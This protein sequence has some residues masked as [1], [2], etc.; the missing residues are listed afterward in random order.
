L[1]DG[2]VDGGGR[3][4]RGRSRWLAAWGR[5]RCGLRRLWGRGGRRHTMNRH[6]SFGD[7]GLGALLGAYEDEVL[8]EI[9]DSHGGGFGVVC[10]GAV[11]DVGD[12]GLCD[13]GSLLYGSRRILEVRVVSFRQLPIRLRIAPQRRPALPWVSCHTT[14]LLHPWS[15][16]SLRRC[17]EAS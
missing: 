12:R 2:V 4:L 16:H 13:A 17:A 3:E 7:A 1:L 14:F 9:E 8:L 11:T 5:R 6:I 15:R 10:G